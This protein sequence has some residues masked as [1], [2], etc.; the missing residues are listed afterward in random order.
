MSYTPTP[1]ASSPASPKTW[2]IVVWALY[3]GGAVT[4][5]IAGIVGLIVAYLKRGD[6][7]GT[8]YASHITSAIRTFWISL[9]A[10]IIGFVLSFV[11]IGL[12]VLIAVGIWSLFRAVRGLLKALDAKP[13]DDPEGWL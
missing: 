8:V 1:D 2:A 13:I 6:V 4:V 11:G 5:G 10:G 12:L 7:A 3:L 9:I